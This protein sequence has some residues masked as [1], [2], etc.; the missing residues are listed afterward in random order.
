MLGL[1]A[2]CAVLFSVVGAGF[3]GNGWAVGASIG[4]LT[5]VII[6]SVHAGLFALTWVY[7]ALALSMSRKVQPTGGS[8]FSANLPGRQASP[9]KETPS[10]EE[11][12]MTPIIMDD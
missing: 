10:A 5:L 9:F 8:P 11:T 4:L 2:V 12:P 3:R 1:T 7:S 6:L